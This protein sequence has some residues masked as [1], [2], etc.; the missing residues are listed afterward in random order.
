MLIELVGGGGLILFHV[1][2]SASNG[3]ETSRNFNEIE[4]STISA[5]EVA[6]WRVFYPIAFFKS[7]LTKCFKVPIFLK[8]FPN[9][10]P[11]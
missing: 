6:R 3:M 7:M 10:A 2:S 4:S 1:P 9:P 5:H 11:S 8:S